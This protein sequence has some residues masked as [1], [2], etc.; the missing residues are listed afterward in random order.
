MKPRVPAE[1]FFA[2]RPKRPELG[3]LKE[4]NKRRCSCGQPMSDKARMC[5][6]CWR[7]KIEL[8]Q[9]RFLAMWYEGATAEEIREELGYKSPESLAARLIRERGWVLPTRR[10]Y[11]R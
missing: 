11:T 7:A 1:D 3:T 2:P 4:R 10:T 6:F 5:K 9:D 8:R